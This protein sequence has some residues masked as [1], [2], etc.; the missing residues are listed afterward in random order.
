[1][2]VMQAP[3]INKIQRVVPPL[4]ETLIRQ[5]RLLYEISKKEHFNGKN[6]HPT[7]LL[8]F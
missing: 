6:I 2:Q 7:S 1:M 4:S 8:D 3:Q 5:S